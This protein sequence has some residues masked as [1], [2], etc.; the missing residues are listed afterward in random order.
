MILF[1]Y[2]TS[3]FI[4]SFLSAFLWAYGGKEG[5]SLAWRRVGVPIV[6]FYTISIITQ[7]WFLSLFAMVVLYGA[8]TL[9]YGVP[10]SQDPGGAIG[11][12]WHSFLRDDGLWT[13]SKITKWTNIM[14]RF[15]VGIA[16]GFPCILLSLVKGHIIWGIAC[17]L[18]SATSTIYWGAIHEDISPLFI[19][20]QKLNAEEFR[21]GGGVGICC[22][23]SLI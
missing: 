19:L 23:L 7:A 13:K 4:A 8:I 16:Y 6:L 20:G 11:K 15:T 17:L 5:T 21:I 2:A 22:L 9:P 10:S 3:F 18:L 1:I 14:T 12:F